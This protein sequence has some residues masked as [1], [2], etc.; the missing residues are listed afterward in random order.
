[1]S[2]ISHLRQTTK[3]RMMSFISMQSK[4][5]EGYITSREKKER[6]LKKMKKY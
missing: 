3:R 5:D 6:A 1:M 4:I 2:V